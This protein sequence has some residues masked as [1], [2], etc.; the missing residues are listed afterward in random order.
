MIPKSYELGFNLNIDNYYLSF[1]KKEL[2]NNFNYI[3]IS[4]KNKHG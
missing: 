4:T 2:L 1:S 3:L